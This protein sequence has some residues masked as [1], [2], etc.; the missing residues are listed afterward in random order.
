MMNFSSVQ[1]HPTV[2][3][4]AGWS[5]QGQSYPFVMICLAIYLE[6][7]QPLSPSPAT[8]SPT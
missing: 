4:L 7:L 3:M 8:P 1:S 5:L 6:A 2:V